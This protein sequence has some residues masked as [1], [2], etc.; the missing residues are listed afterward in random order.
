MHTPTVDVKGEGVCSLSIIYETKKQMYC[1][2]VTVP[3]PV[4]IITNHIILILEE[5]W[6]RVWGER[7]VR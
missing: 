5:V 2:C 7:G 4:P 6:G 1:M 3:S